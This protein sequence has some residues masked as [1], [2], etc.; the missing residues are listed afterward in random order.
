[1]LNR[2]VHWVCIPIEMAAVLGLLSMIR[3]GP[4][5]GGIVAVLVLGALYVATDVVLGT[6]WTSA[7]FGLWFL[8]RSVLDG[9]PVWVAV[10]PVA[11][12]AV[13]FATQLVVGHRIG[14][15]G[16][17][18]T[19]MNLFCARSDRNVVPLLLVFYYHVVELAFM[20]GYRP[21]VR[22]QVDAVTRREIERIEAADG[23]PRYVC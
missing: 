8:S 18:D 12:F 11:L 14:E 2:V 6:V 20:A 22:A 15:R 1:M 21:D 10:V 4:V 7:L 5:D 3:M 9:R 23:A 17:D 19:S 16:L 13:T